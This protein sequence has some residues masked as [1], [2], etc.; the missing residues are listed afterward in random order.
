MDPL[1]SPWQSPLLYVVDVKVIV[2]HN[3]FE[4]RLTP[5]PPLFVEKKAR[6]RRI[7]S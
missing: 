4:R 1:F 5:R 3:L 6:C 2:E 7:A